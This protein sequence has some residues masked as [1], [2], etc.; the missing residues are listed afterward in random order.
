VTVQEHLLSLVQIRPRIGPTRR[1]QPHDEHRHVHQHAG[2][3]DTGR[4]EVDLGLLAQRVMLRNHHLHQRHVH[5][6]SDLSHIAAHRRL[7]H[8]RPVLLAQALPHPTSRVPLLARRRAVRLQPP[9]DCRLPPVQ[10][11]RRPLRHLAVRWH[12]RRQRLTRITAMDMKTASQLTN[13]QLL[14][15]TDLADLLVQRHLRPLGHRPRSTAA[16]P[17]RWT[18]KGGAKSDDPVSSGRRN[19]VVL[20]S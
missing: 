7:A 14:A 16:S 4:P 5:P 18:L 9:V 11:R 15:F 3:I 17:H 19:T 13:R 2:H 10:R 20:G 6:P 12:R 1:R 8:L